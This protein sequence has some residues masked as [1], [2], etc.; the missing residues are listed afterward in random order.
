[1]LIDHVTVNFP[2]HSGLARDQVV[3]T[4]T[5][6]AEADLDAGALTTIESALTDFYN[7]STVAGSGLTVASFIGPTMS[8]TIAPTF[9]HYDLD[10]HLNGTAVGSPVRVQS[11]ALLGAG[12][13]G[14]GLPAEVA[15]CLSYHS[16]FGTDAEF[17]P[18]GL[19]RPRSRDRGR[20]FIGPLSATG[21]ITQEATTLRPRVSDSLQQT[22]IDAGRRLFS[23]PSLPASWVVWSRKAAA[24]HN[25]IQ[26]SVDDAFDTQRRRGE[27]P[28]VR[29]NWLLP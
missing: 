13:G 28:N 27:R 9:K 23:F 17:G 5:F 10:G 25:V 7:G 2:H 15:C 8:R 12:N 24:V 18:G 16:A 1:V 22:L 20:V 4:W 14:T 21:C 19:T 26:I 29:F 6:A 3:N 11:M